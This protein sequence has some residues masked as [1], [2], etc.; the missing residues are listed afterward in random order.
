M[1]PAFRTTDAAGLAVAKLRD[2]WA[3][4]HAPTGQPVVASPA[5][6]RFARL[7]DARAAALR[8]APVL[9]WTRPMEELAPL[10]GRH[11]WSATKE[12]VFDAL[13]DSTAAERRAERERRR[14]ERSGEPE[15]EAADAAARR[16]GHELTWQSYGARSWRGT[17]RRCGL[18]V[19]VAYSPRQR[20]HE[21]RGERMVIEAR[22]R[23]PG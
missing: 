14:R 23:A 13:T 17:C 18:A 21:L 16:L 2:G 22:C 19:R 12:A 4:V 1:T 3:V 5:H 7:R 10:I 6:N 15:R 8:L 20:R 11:V 9:D